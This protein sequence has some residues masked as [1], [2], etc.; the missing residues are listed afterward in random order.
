MTGRE[1][2]RPLS[3]RREGRFP[4]NDVD[5]RERLHRPDSEFVAVQDRRDDPG[6]VSLQRSRDERGPGDLIRERRGRLEERD[7]FA[8]DVTVRA[9]DGDPPSTS[10]VPAPV[11]REIVERLAENPRER[12]PCETGAETFRPRSRFP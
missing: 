11:R 7:P 2:Q 5:F 8:R 10:S 1:D 9:S 4:L 6:R 3:L 12:V